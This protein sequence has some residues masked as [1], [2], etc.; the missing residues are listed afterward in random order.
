M[1]YYKKLSSK[2]KC[3]VRQYTGDSSTT[4][5][6][7]LI[8][9]NE[10]TKEKNGFNFSENTWEKISLLT[11]VIIN[12]PIGSTTVYHYHKKGYLEKTKRGDKILGEKAN[13]IITTSFKSTTDNENVR[14]FL[15]PFKNVGCCQ[16]RINLVNFPIFKVGLDSSYKDQEEVILP[17]YILYKTLNRNKITIHEYAEDIV[18]KCTKQIARKDFTRCIGGHNDYVI[19]TTCIKNFTK[20]SDL[21]DT[22]YGIIKSEYINRKIIDEINKVLKKYYKC[23]P[24]KSYHGKLHICNTILLSILLLTEITDDFKPHLETTILSSLFHDSGRECK[25]GPDK[26]QK[27]SASISKLEVNSDI[28]YENIIDNPRKGEAGVS[29]YAY[30]GADSIDIGRVIPYD[31][32]LNPL[33]G[34]FGKG[35]QNIISKSS[36]HDEFLALSY[37][38]FKIETGELADTEIIIKKRRT[39]GKVVYISHFDLFPKYVLKRVEK[40]FPITDKSTEDKIEKILTEGDIASD[41]II[42]M[43]AMC[44]YFISKGYLRDENRY[45]DDYYEIV[46]AF[47][48]LLPTTSRLLPRIIIPFRHRDLFS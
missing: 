13:D 9:N 27:E 34:K 29:Y 38:M 11:S 12:A 4:M 47:L 44:E 25:D 41:S 5:N 21:V 8:E 28:I 22:N 10:L 6:M 48:P 15:T 40:D 16:R 30:K 35:V 14:E 17:P 7:Y 37:Y 45:F 19:D 31:K 46:L 18:K 32:K 23:E 36:L 39:P 43:N 26:W 2:A 42:S 20:Q 3:V 33:Y 24:G 1:S